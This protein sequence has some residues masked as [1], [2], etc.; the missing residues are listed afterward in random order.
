MAMTLEAISTMLDELEFTHT[1]RT[2]DSMIFAG[3]G[4]SDNRLGYFID[5]QEDGEIFQMDARPLDDNGDLVKAK[6]H[7]HLNVLMSYLLLR[8]YQTKFGTWEYNNE[9]GTVRLMV[10]IPLEDNDLTKKQLNRIIKMM[11]SCSKETG[12]IKH[13]LAHGSLPLEGDDA[14]K[15]IAELEAMLAQLQGSTSGI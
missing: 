5:L 12:D 11:L 10:E 6:D 1:L 7:K 4:S 3:G 8:N 13:I 9:N 14:A 15:R 2:E